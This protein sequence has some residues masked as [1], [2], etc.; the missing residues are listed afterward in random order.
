MDLKVSNRRR[1]QEERHKF[2]Y[3]T[4]K[5]NFPRFAR[6]FFIISNHDDDGKERHKFAY[7]TT[8]NNSFAR[9][10]RAFFIFLHFAHILVVS[11]FLV[12]SGS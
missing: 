9:F 8:K 2:A 3:L 6:A 12:V 7:L 5:N 1:R 10:A 11:T 4:V